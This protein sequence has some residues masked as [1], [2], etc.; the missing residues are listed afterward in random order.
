[1]TWNNLYFV[2]VNTV[3]YCSLYG[4]KLDPEPGRCRRTDGKKWRCSK[5]AYADS[6]YC[7]RHMNRGRNR[8]RKPVESAQN[9]ISLSHNSSSS[10][11]SSSSSTLS[12]LA[13]ANSGSFRTF[14]LV[15]AGVGSSQLCLD[16]GGYGM[17]SSLLH[18]KTHSIQN[19]TS[20]S[21]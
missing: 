1:M 20:P 4:K 2:D 13:S 7:E 16:S 15:S 10:A 18:S 3:G 21:Q 11:S 9:T 19:T 8:S 5:D 12:A 6:K 17:A 14:P